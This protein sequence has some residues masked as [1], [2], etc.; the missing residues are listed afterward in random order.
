MKNTLYILVASII[1][2]SC[3]K[4]QR[5]SMGSEL[6]GRELVVYAIQGSY[7]YVNVNS[8]YGRSV[9][10]M[11][12]N[13]KNRGIHFKPDT[14]VNQKWY[15]ELGDTA[16]V[17]FLS[18]YTSSL[19]IRFPLPNEDLVIEKYPMRTAIPTSIL[20]GNYQVQYGYLP[21]T[22]QR[23]WTLTKH[24]RGPQGQIGQPLVTIQLLDR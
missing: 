24:D 11:S 13:P 14:L 20:S 5:L 10:T 18:S 17:P 23:G 19:E 21:G 6:E 2:M 22:G 1:A 9:M 4:E 3:R 12:F 15:R 16:F 7:N 8:G